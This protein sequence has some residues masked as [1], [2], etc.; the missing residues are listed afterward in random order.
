MTDYELREYTREDCPAMAALWHTAF[1]DPATLTD[2]FLRLLPQLGT[3]AVASAGGEL[4]GAAYVITGLELRQGTTR[5][6]C[7]YVYAVAVREDARGH[8]IGGALVRK[9]CALARERGAALC[10]TEPA[11]EGLFRWYEQAADFT[12]LLR[13]RSQEC[14]CRPVWPVMALSATEY[15]CWREALCRD[16]ARLVPS[17]PV[18][19]LL[20]GMC[21]L[22]GGGLY[23]CGSGIAAAVREGDTAVFYE[24]IAPAEDRA[25][26]AAAVG[27]A[28]GCTRARYRSPSPEG[29]AFLAADRALP[30]TLDFSFTFE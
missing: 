23:A 21:T 6:V 15:L 4:L 20:H 12:H 1:G 22:C 11:D 16:E 8:G 25:E 30:E 27:N 19:E 13:R 10:C 2:C 5:Q 24:L 17:S 14:V 3:A 9:V 26:L 7:G 18:I 28:M 29:A